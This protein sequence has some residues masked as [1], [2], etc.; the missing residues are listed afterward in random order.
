MGDQLIPRVFHRVWFG[1]PMP[2]P[3][4]E[5]GRTW[6][7]H[8]PGWEMRTWNDRNLP[9]L[10]NRRLFD[11]SSVWAEK[12]DIVRYE[13]LHRYGGVYIDTDFECRKNLEPLLAGVDALAA[14]EDGR[15]VS[16]SIIGT[17]PGHP[18]MARMIDAIARSAGSGPDAP[19]NE[20]TGPKLFSE[21]LESLALEGHSPTVFPARWFYP[22]HFSEPE[23]RHEAF[24]EAYAVHHWAG[25]WSAP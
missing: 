12:S 11:A 19:V 20:R 15:W 22:Y 9:P 2:A 7:R 1:R 23:R 25:S 18:L 21:V 13:L 6:M 24:P 8:H 16:N 5:Y 4:E 10:R 14:T 3:F 17:T